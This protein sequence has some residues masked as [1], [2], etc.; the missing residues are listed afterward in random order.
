MADDVLM[1]IGM[2]SRSS[3]L[4]IKALR[5]YH[6]Q[7]LLI[8]AE[9]DPDTGYRS[10]HIAQL[11]DAAVLRRLRE[12]DLPLNEVKEI[13]TLRDPEVT[14]KVLETHRVAMETRL[15]E[16]ERIVAELQ[17]AAQEPAVQTPV[18]TTVTPH[19]HALAISGTVA[20][21]D[22]AAFLGPAFETLYRTAMTG[23]SI[24]GPGGALYTAEIHDSDQEPITTFVPV[25]EP[26][27]IDEV[28]TGVKV[29]E[30]P[31]ET[32]AV[33]V[34]HGGY[35]TIDQTYAALGAWVARHASSSNRP[36]RE[37]YLVSVQDTADS[38]EFRTQIGWPVHT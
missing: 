10:Y 23:F 4:S 12:L 38:N 5:L 18:H 25:A 2:F 8:P 37:D 36:I 27:P 34:H 16:V 29:I 14:R 6:S 24:S 13:L 31:Q 35:E 11:T 15:L 28:G 3:L 1:S 21:D 26:G 33:V 32:M 19:T 30:L 17:A 20:S 9:V 22:F 7:G